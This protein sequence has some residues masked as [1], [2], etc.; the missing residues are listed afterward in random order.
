MKE[1]RI[2]I[3]GLSILLS[4][5]SVSTF[6]KFEAEKGVPIFIK[7]GETT[8]NEVFEKLGEPLVHRFEARKETVIYNHEQGEYFSC[9]E[10]ISGMNW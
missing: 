4:G 5:C 1:F 6:G 3:T 9:M 10:H 7:T 8:R 2:S